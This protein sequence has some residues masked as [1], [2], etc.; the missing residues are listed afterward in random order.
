MTVMHVV[1]ERKNVE[2]TFILFFSTIDHYCF[3][4]NRND[5]GREKKENMPE[6][7]SVIYK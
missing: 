2:S 1:E 6:K 3:M 7:I 5:M 4:Q